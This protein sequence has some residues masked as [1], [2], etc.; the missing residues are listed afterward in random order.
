[1]LQLHPLT[2]GYKRDAEPCN[3]KQSKEYDISRY[4]IMHP[5]VTRH[6]CHVERIGL[7]YSPSKAK[8]LNTFY[9]K[10]G[11]RALSD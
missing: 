3:D 8:G 10:D 6:E 11:Q 7:H 9:G 1:M 4:K 5:C 2:D